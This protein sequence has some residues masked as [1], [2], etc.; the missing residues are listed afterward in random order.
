[1]EEKLKHSE[2]KRHLTHNVYTS[3]YENQ[4]ERPYSVNRDAYS[5]NSS[6]DLEHCM[7]YKKPNHPA[8]I[9]NI[10]WK[11][12]NFQIINKL[13]NDGKVTDKKGVFNI[14]KKR[15]L[16]SEKDFLRF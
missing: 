16:Y 4:V 5:G 3:S 14:T 12:N 15:K 6:V 2:F 11:Q 1:M 7:E 10:P 8:T 13:S 9:Q